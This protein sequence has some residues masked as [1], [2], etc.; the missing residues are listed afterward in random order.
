M[1]TGKFE[2]KDCALPKRC[3]I[4]ILV[5]LGLIP[6][7]SDA[8]LFAANIMFSPRTLCFSHAVPLSASSKC[9]ANVMT[10]EMRITKIS[11]LF[12][13]CVAS[14]ASRD[15]MIDGRTRCR[16]IGSRGGH[17]GVSGMVNTKVAMR[18]Q[19]SMSL[20]GL[21]P[22]PPMPAGPILAATEISFHN[23]CNSFVGVVPRESPSTSMNKDFPDLAWASASWMMGRT[24]SCHELGAFDVRMREIRPVFDQS[25]PT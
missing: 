15:R 25:T 16:N 4:A 2:T 13:C 7:R 20:A 24:W 14:R 1:N 12:I 5:G 11:M 23:D 21:T 19:F 18:R 3:K 9:S 6:R 17:V 8:S 22:T 10:D